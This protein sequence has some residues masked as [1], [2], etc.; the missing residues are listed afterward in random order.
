MKRL[1]IIAYYWPPSGG[2][3]V[4]RWLK[5]V[6][7][8][9]AYNWQPV[10]YTPDNPD[11]SL[12]DESLLKE[13]PEEAEILR[14]KIW[15]PYQLKR[16][17]LGGRKDDNASNGLVAS[18]DSIKS[19]LANWI[20]GNLFIPDPKIFWRK[21]SLR[22]LKKYLEENPVDAI[23]STGT[24]HSMHL[25]AYDLK[26]QLGIP[27]IADFRDPWSQLDMLKGYHILPFRMRKYEA[28]EKRVIETADLCLTTSNLWAE[29]FRRLGAR[30][31]EVITNGFDESDFD[32][33]V[34]PYD[35]F[36][37][38][39]FGLMNHLRDPEHLWKALADLCEE[40][41]E[42]DKKLKIH[43][44]GTIDEGN[45]EKIRC[46]D[47]L[48]G[49]LKV[50][51][52]LSHKE[53]IEEYF[54][55]SILLLLLFNSESGAGNIPGK[56]FEYLATAK[57]IVAFGSGEGDSSEI[58]RGSG[59]YFYRYQQSHEEIKEGISKLFEQWSTKATGI[60]TENIMKYS[61]KSLTGK[62]ANYLA[63]LS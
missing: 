40:N 2:S 51:P 59:G 7:Y 46:Y 11:F 24:P 32:V 21:P 4:Q 16:S 39:H 35:D 8:L 37:I 57:P 27:W 58:V 31:V 48:R 9:P 20:R 56:L 6:K 42:L 10:V 28:M 49:K 1:L 25:I 5:F 62:L 36:V 55:S 26:K 22:F 19:G 17:I 30:R 3:G 53:V 63:E 41:K 13:V 15:E 47:K 43:L 14:N 52:Y 34:T 23:V 44:G 33:T 60:Q 54:K 18:G 12:K 61:R 50:F 29:D 38:S 45:L